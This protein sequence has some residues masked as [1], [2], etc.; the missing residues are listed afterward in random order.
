MKNQYFGDI[1]DLFKYDLIISIIREIGSIN[2]FIFIP[3]LTRNDNRK[4]GNK[5]DYTTAKAGTHNKGLI[6]Y[7]E[8]RVN[9]NRR[10]V[11]EIKEYFKSNGI[12]IT[13]Y[14][15]TEYF[16]HKLRADYFKNIDDKVLSNSLMLL[17]PDNGLEIKQ[18]NEKLF[19]FGRLKPFIIAWRGVLF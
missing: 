15:E 1:R 9:E 16:N 8:K 18:S 4:D 7:L 2:R 3:L 14:R 5:I 12:E 11:S 19:C 6:E 13:I 10:E 17:D